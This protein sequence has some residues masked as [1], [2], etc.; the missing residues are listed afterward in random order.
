MTAIFS[1]PAVARLTLAALVAACLT[2]A[3]ATADTQTKQDKFQLTQGDFTELAFAP[4]AAG[5]IKANATFKGSGVVKK[6]V[7]LRMQLVEAA[8]GKVLKEAV[9][10]NPL[11]LSFTLSA[12]EL[13]AVKGKGLKVVLRHNV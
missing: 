4:G 3:T 10:G 12:A 8:S 9:G 5:Q 6:D 1:R 13:N 2:S 7:A 11:P